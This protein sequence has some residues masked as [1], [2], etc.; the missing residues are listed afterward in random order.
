[1]QAVANGTRHFY[2]KPSYQTDLAQDTPLELSHESL[3]LRRSAALSAHNRLVLDRSPSEEGHHLAKVAISDVLLD[4]RRHTLLQ[5]GL[6]LSATGGPDWSNAPAMKSVKSSFM[7]TQH[8]PCI[9][10]RMCWSVHRTAGRHRSC[11]GHPRATGACRPRL[12]EG[13][14][15]LGTGSRRSGDMTPGCACQTRH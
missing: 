4:Q 6:T 1:M 7:P 3:A 2:P 15:L 13:P 8:Q 11:P 5:A 12:T 14:S 10:S 9:T